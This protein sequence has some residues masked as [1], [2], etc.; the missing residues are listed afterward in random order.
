MK[1]L[2]LAAGYGT[3]LYPIV[4]D[5]PKPLLE[6]Q[7][8]PL[9]NYLVEKVK[10]IAGLS[11][12]LVVTNDKF[13][14]DFTV[15]S[16]G[17]SGLKAK[18]TIVNDGTKTPEDRLGS[19]GD[20]D[21]VLKNQHINEDLFVLGGDNL[22]DYGLGDFVK[23]AQAQVPNVSIGL[24]DIHDQNAATRFGVVEL[25]AESRKV[26]SFEEKPA[27]P[28]STLIAMCSYYFP[29]ESLGLLHEYLNETHKADK[30]GEYI[31]WLVEK[32]EVYG[33]EF[34][35]SWYDIGSVESLQEAQEKFRPKKHL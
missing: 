28:R 30:A 13:F 34:E 29:K 24:Y 2:I 15:W 14:N 31:H 27:T 9:I 17:F 23:F 18:V 19:I 26:L 33:F 22:F 11:E 32:K 4:R 10:D 25:C 6:I 3:R 12:I 16:K 20:I 1:V 21:F 8:S 35:G 7:G 5:T